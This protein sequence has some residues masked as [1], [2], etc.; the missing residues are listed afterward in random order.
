MPED[1]IAEISFN[2]ELIDKIN[3]DDYIKAV[4]ELG[5]T[6]EM[7]TSEDVMTRTLHKLVSKGT[8]IDSSFYDK[9][10][11]HKLL[12]PLDRSVIISNG[13]NTDSLVAE[14]MTMMNRDKRFNYMFMKYGDLPLQLMRNVHL[15]NQISLKITIIKQAM[16]RLFKHMIQ[17][18]LL[19][20]YIGLK[21][22]LKNKELIQLI[23]ASI[24]HDISE[25]H[26]NPDLQNPE[27]KMSDEDWT[28]VYAHPIVSFLILREF[29][30]YNTSISNIVLEHHEKLDGSGYPRGKLVDE[31]SKAGQIL[32][33]ADTISAL[34]EKGCLCDEIEAKI[35]MNQGQYNTKYL[36]TVISAL[37]ST[38]HYEDTETKAYTLK[39]V[40][41]KLG[42]VGKIIQEWHDIFHK[43]T[44]Q[45]KNQLLIDTINKRI[46]YIQ[47]QLIGSGLDT[48]Q[49]DQ[50]Y[51][52]L[53]E[54]TGEWLHDTNS[55]SNE[56]IFQLSTTVKE[57]K[58]NWPE[59]N[60]PHKARS[61]GEYL[62]TWMSDTEQCINS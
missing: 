51:I 35:S 46:K 22:G 62:S 37:K 9:L 41:E 25:L 28:Q 55:I 32:A 34:L 59:Y 56:A 7:V 29:P 50:I 48:E 10:I 24:L 19:A 61:L 27:Y 30:V 42:L 12:K 5:D 47:M 54:E 39:R 1:N 15:E 20:L 36:Y 52:L 8:Q 2:N 14:A 38:A 31:I 16:P 49:L 23:T 11:Q 26:I 57:A 21:D 43:L 45:Q 17:T 18:A 40:D 60:A 53:G 13:I 6:K 44:E 3:S 33:V 58:R 4:T